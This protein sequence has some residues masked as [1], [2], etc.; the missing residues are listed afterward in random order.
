MGSAQGI[1]VIN[2]DNQVSQILFLDSVHKIQ[3]PRNKLTT[4]NASLRCIK[5]KQKTWCQPLP[6]ALTISLAA[7]WHGGQPNDVAHGH[8]MVIG[9]LGTLLT[10][11]KIQ[12]EAFFIVSRKLSG[13]EK[14]AQSASV[15]SCEHVAVE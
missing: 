13:M 5:H 12:R 8:G 2:I 3:V 6:R 14:D 11:T 9:Y 10:E 15:V 1:K 7:V 4:E